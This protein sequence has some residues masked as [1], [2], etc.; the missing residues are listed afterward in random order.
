MDGFLNLHLAPWLRRLVTRSL[1]LIPAVLVVALRGSR[2]IY[3]LLIFSQV[4][5]SMQLSFAVIPLIMFTSDRRKMGEFVNP[6]WVRLLAWTL[7]V[8]IAS[9]NLL[10]LYHQVG[11]PRSPERAPLGS[12][13]TGPALVARGL[14]GGAA[15][16]AAPAAPAAAGP[17]RT[18]GRG[19]APLRA[20]TASGSARGS[21]SR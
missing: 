8:A 9:L 3:D 14:A 5:L 17:P 2:G 19:G 18:G 10:L 13:E 20:G 21:C 12:A 7:A 15:A 4:I 6:A 11:P 16:A 1:A